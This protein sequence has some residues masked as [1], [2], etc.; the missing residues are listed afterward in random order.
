MQLPILPPAQ[1]SIP[2]GCSNDF[3]AGFDIIYITGR[4]GLDSDILQ[5]GGFHRSADN[6]ALTDVC[7]KLRQK[8]ILAAAADNPD[9]LQI[10]AG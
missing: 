9:G 2:S 6:I 1:E 3:T 10:L 8:L 7:R 4:N 5:S